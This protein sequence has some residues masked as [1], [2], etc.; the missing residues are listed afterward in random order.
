[1]TFLRWLTGDE[2]RPYLFGAV[3]TRGMSGNG[4]IQRDEGEGTALTRI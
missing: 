1:M 3:T 4:K 2:G